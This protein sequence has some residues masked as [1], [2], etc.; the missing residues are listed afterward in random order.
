MEGYW[1]TRKLALCL[2]SRRVGHHAG[3]LTRL[4]G[5]ESLSRDG[6]YPLGAAAE[7]NR[8]NLVSNREAS[9][10]LRRYPEDLEDLAPTA[11]G[12]I[13]RRYER[14][15]GRP[16]GLDII[17]AAPHLLLV[18]KASDVAYVRDQRTQLDL[19]T[20][21]SASCLAVSVVSALLLAPC[22]WWMLLA[23]VP[24]LLA[25]MFYRG[26]CVVAQ[27]YGVSL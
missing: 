19:A 12:N 11:L 14:G 4:Q 23:V 13:L 9:R 5:I 10:L 27:E 1:G 6:A 15:A 8:D 16:Y 25:Q 17:T 26:A 22:G 3:M 24:Y 18:A 7:A 20:R 21:L 2:A